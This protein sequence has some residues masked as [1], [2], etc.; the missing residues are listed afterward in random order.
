[1]KQCLAKDDRP[2]PARTCDGLAC[3]TPFPPP[4]PDEI[5]LED[6][7][8]KYFYPEAATKQDSLIEIA[9]VQ[10]SVCPEL[11]D[12][13]ES[14]HFIDWWRTYAYQI[15]TEPAKCSSTT[16]KT[17]FAE[18]Q[19][20]LHDALACAAKKQ[21]HDPRY[22][23][24]GPDLFSWLEVKCTGKLNVADVVWR[25]EVFSFLSNID[26]L[27]DQLRRYSSV[28]GDSESKALVTALQTFDAIKHDACGAKDVQT[29]INEYGVWRDYPRLLNLIRDDLHLSL[30]DPNQK[31]IID[32]FTN[33][34]N[35][36][37]DMAIC[38]ALQDASLSR[39]TGYDR[40]TYCVS[41]GL[42]EYMAVASTS[43]GHTVERVGTGPDQGLAYEFET[44]A[45]GHAII[46]K[47]F[48]D[49]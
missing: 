32:A 23:E 21:I 18:R 20:E 28:M 2:S 7:D 15:V 19:K 22:D 33:L 14:Q 1:M 17:A 24:S 36:I 4:L 9:S 46:I 47:E 41:H 34:D 27:I 3:S 39:L 12:R 29:C 45:T 30:V 31:S 25:K 10:P 40:A 11:R 26:S 49:K 5:A 16:W 43:V 44:D 13:E 38:D 6:Y 37:V 42:Q 35:V 8:T 48:P